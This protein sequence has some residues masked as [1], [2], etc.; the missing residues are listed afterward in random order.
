ME[1]DWVVELD[2]VAHGFFECWDVV[3]VDGFYVVVV[4]RFE[5][6]WGLDVFAHRGFDCFYVAFGGVIYDW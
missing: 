1:H 5:E 4:E 6:C 2:A 3:V